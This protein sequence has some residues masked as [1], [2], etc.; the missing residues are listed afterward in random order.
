MCIYTH[1]SDDL[2]NTFQTI[3]FLNLTPQNS[4]YPIKLRRLGFFRHTLKQLF[5][6]NV[7]LQQENTICFSLLILKFVIIKFTTRQYFVVINWPSPLY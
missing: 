5:N 4:N 6:N 7:V 1:I 3:Q 2:T